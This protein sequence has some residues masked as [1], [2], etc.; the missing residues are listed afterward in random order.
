METRVACA[1]RDVKRRGLSG[2]GAVGGELPAL[3][4]CV[5][6]SDVRR[7]AWGPTGCAA[8]RRARPADPWRHLA[9]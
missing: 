2:H 4:D 8:D 1:P 3:M 5:G 9:L 6:R 7:R